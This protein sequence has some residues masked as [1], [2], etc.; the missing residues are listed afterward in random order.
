MT[1]PDGSEARP[2]LPHA[3]LDQR[4]ISLEN[5]SYFFVIGIAILFIGG[6]YIHSPPN[7]LAVPCQMD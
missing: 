6:S 7:L 5:T 1:Y 3:S 4:Y 2:W